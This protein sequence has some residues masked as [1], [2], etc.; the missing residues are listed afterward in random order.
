[1]KIDPPADNAINKKVNFHLYI[2][3]HTISLP[4]AE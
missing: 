1:M 2:L 4:G 3:S